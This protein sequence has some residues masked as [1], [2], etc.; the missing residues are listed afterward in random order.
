MVHSLLSCPIVDVLY[1][2]YIRKLDEHC[3]YVLSFRYVFMR[4]FNGFESA[5]QLVSFM[6]V[7]IGIVCMEN[8]LSNV[9]EYLNTLFESTNG[10]QFYHFHFKKFVVDHEF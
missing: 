7:Q 5:T 1:Y 10:F 4:N 8:E 2:N 6:S 9:I 3:F